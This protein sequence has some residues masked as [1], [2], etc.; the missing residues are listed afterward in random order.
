MSICKAVQG[1]ILIWYP[2]L[3]KKILSLYGF[4]GTLLLLSGISLHTIP[5]M[6]VMQNKNKTQST[7]LRTASILLFFKYC[8]IA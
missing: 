6:I 4:R 3:L 1:L 5:G 2:H 8:R 7:I